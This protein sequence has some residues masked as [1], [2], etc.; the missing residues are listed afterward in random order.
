MVP[1]ALAV[2]K[3][4]NVDEALRQLMKERQCAKTAYE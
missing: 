1:S 3:A 4:H 2:V